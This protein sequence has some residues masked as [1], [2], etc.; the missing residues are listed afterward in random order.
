MK[1]NDL[2]KY[3]T[4]QMVSRIENSNEKN[5][6]PKQK[7]SN[8]STRWFGLIPLSIKMLSDRIRKN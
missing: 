8:F 2:V 1:T 7:N 3:L 6:K 4:I 5:F